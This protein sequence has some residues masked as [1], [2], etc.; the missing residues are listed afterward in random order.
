MSEL[1]YITEMLESKDNNIKFYENCYHKEKIKGI[2]HKV[3]EGILTYQHIYCYKYRTLFDDNFEKHGFITSNI[4]IPDVAGFKTILRLKKQR[5]LCKHCG[6]AFTLR[7]NVTDYGCFISKNTKWK[8]A[9][10]L[11][12]KISEKDIAKNNNFIKILK[13]IAFGFKSFK[14]FKTRIIICKGL[15]KINRK[16]ANAYALA[17]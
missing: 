1:N 5:Y 3:F 13:R 11:R 4:K 16:K 10:E 15:V 2:I 6:K 9:N 7:D 17:S 12:N 14:R 8:I